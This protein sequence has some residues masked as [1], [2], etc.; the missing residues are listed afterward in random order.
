MTFTVSVV[1]PVYNAA[2]YVA[3]AVETALAQPETAEVL[4]VEDGS[5]D[6]SLAICE[7]LAAAN[8]R[9]HLYRHPG[10]QNRGAS[11]SRN[12]AI[13]HSRQDYIAFLDADDYFLPERF[14]LTRELFDRHPD[15]D[16][17]YEAIGATFED[18]AAEARWDPRRRSSMVTMVRERVPPEGLL[19]LLTSGR[20]GH[21]SIIG[22]AVKRSL[23]EETGPFDV[24]RR[25]HQDSVMIRKMAAVGRLIPGDLDRPVVMRHIH[26][27]N[28]S[29]AQRP[30]YQVLATRTRAYAATWRWARQHLDA[31]RQQLILDEFLR[32]IA[33]FGP[34]PTSRLLARLASQSKLALLALVYPALLTEREYW[35]HLSSHRLP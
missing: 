9:V 26:R 8:E 6:G 10:G 33:N 23:L 19:A 28:R 27:D 13:Q 17:V 7:R 1:I 29:S 30:W 25:L 15:A 35:K 24:A 5:T 16:G 2:P 20:A 31:D 11:A 3:Q 21:F 34:T 18:Q 14:R 22:L 12:L 4:L 32:Q